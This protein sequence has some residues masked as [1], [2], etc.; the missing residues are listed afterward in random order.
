[1][2]ATTVQATKIRRR[3]VTPSEGGVTP[4]LQSNVPAPTVPVAGNLLDNTEH[5]GQVRW[6]KGVLFGPPKTG[7][8]VAA[9]SGRGR[10][11][12]I[13][14]EPEGDLSL[15]GREDVDVVR[16]TNWAQLNEILQG[17]YSSHRDKWD[18]VIFDSVT[19]MFELIGAKGI[20]SAAAANKD[21]RRQY[22]NA[23]AAVNQ[24][25]YDAV[26]LP[27]NV[28][29]TCQLK[30]DSPDDEAGD[31][32]LDPTVGEYNW[33]LALTP[34]VFKVLAPAVSFIGRTFKKFGYAARTEGAVVQRKVAEYWVSFEDFGKS[35]AGARIP[36]PE[37]VKNLNMDEL[38]AAVQD[39]GRSA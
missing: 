31:T 22:L 32:P 9:C 23:G 6:L 2:P 13:L 38:L 29:F 19:F 14:M 25:I 17:L 37:Q 5:P 3:V 35:P 26:R 27:M 15:A 4:S 21:V 24:L 20:L 16:P 12:L 30:V 8:T 18:T 39:N 36:V 34:M 7:K 1:M 10:K 28:I 33:T 11:L